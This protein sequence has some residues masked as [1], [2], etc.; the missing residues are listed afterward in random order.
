MLVDGTVVYPHRPDLAAKRFW[1]C[2]PCQAWCGC[3]PGSSRPLGVPAT[4]DLRKARQMLHNDRLDPLWKTAIETVGYTP[5]DPR[6]RAIITNTARSR[7]YEFLAWKLGIDR[8]DCHTALFDIATCRLAWTA[9][10]G[11]TYPA[12]RDWAKARKAAR[13][14]Q[15]ERAHG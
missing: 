5:E 11:A 1:R 14:Q 12:I 4:A 9:L 8:E 15:E 7:V 6:A 2:A 10:A 3:H 13:Q